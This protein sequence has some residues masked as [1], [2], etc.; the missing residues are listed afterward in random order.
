VFLPKLITTLIRWPAA[1]ISSLR[2]PEA[3]A[4]SP[5]PG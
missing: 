3:K 1:R 4:V 2:A 5:V